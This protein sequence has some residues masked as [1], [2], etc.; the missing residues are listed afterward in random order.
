LTTDATGMVSVSMTEGPNYRN[1]IEI[2]GTTGAMRI[3]HNGHLFISKTGEQ[4]WT[5]VDIGFH[6]PLAGYPDS[7]F[8]R[9]FVALAP[10][11]VNALRNQETS[12]PDAATFE[13]GLEVQKVLDA[14]RAADSEGRRTTIIR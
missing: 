7:G 11:I 3:E 14:A 6:D 10:K 13:D 1:S 9:G 5:E 8:P 12:I 2:F 4:G